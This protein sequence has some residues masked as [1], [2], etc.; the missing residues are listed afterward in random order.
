[1]SVLPHKQHTPPWKIF[2][3]LAT[4]LELSPVVPV[5]FFGDGPSR[6]A[7]ITTYEI[8]HDFH[9]FP[10]PNPATI[11]SHVSHGLNETTRRVVVSWPA[12]RRAGEPMDLL[13]LTSAQRWW[14]WWYWTSEIAAWDKHPTQIFQHFFLLLSCLVLVFKKK[15]LSWAD[16]MSCVLKILCVHR[17][18]REKKR[19][20]KRATFFIICQACLP[21]AEILC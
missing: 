7:L 1:M 8:K 20:K 6:K 5:W 3:S 16:E 15:E 13:R 18:M 11:A 21:R 2:H 4:A 17:V 19:R 10:P 12:R 14:C 9:I